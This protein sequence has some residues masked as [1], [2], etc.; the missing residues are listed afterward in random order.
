MHLST[1]PNMLV[2]ITVLRA[3]F[4][5]KEG[6]YNYNDKA[7]VTADECSSIGQKYRAYKAVG[8][9]IYADLYGKNMPSK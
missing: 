9:C 5:C 1:T 6:L 8:Y 4:P 3:W 7:C 2:L